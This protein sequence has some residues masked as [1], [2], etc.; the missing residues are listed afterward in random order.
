MTAPT[1]MPGGCDDHE[2]GCAGRL[3]ARAK[4]MAVSSARAAAVAQA[5]YGVGVAWPENAA[6]DEMSL[7]RKRRGPFLPA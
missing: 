3:P 2:T 5:A 4:L 1:G 6:Q 7:P